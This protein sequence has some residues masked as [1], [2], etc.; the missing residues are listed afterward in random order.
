MN[1]ITLKQ[2]CFFL[3]VLALPIVSYGQFTGD[4]VIVYV[5][6][7]AEI[8]VAVD[9][10]TDLAKSDSV[11]IALDEFRKI[12]AEIEDQLSPEKA[13]L[14]KYSFGSSLTIEPGD[15]KIIYLNKDGS[16][17]NTGFRDQAIISGEKYVISITSTDLSKL[18]DLAL[19][20]CMNKVKEQ[21]PEK[22]H[23]PKSISYECTGGVITELENKN[24][25]TDFLELQLGAGAGLIKSKWVADISFGVSLG[26]NHK[27]ML[28]S[29]YVSTNMIFDFDPEN[30][31]SINTFLNVGYR[32]DVSRKEDKPDILGVELGYLISQQGELF[33]DNTFKLG[34]NW[35]PA[36]NIMVTPT[37]YVTD[38]FN[39]AFPGVRIGFGF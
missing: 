32:F 34:V 27:G 36:K 24:N 15:S 33:G 30:N 3:I 14:V 4:T 13:D 25:S 22:E 39:Q 11:N 6:N 26:L 1:K 9:D 21:L 10:Y 16:L 19:S 2:L 38:N 23:W 17:T 35:S 7:R 8:K 37:L 12:L 5:D 29:P 18:A 20:D 28:R 31:M